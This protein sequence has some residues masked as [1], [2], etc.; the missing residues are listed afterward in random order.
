MAT[1][2]ELMRAMLLQSNGVGARTYGGG[3]A[4]DHARGRDFERFRS[5]PLGKLFL[6]ESMDAQRAAFEQ[7]AR[8]GAFNMQYGEMPN[9]AD[10][11]R[12]VNKALGRNPAAAQ[13]GLIPG[14]DSGPG[15]IPGQVGL[16]GP[17][18][19]A[20]AGGLGLNDGQLSA[21]ISLS[22][23]ADDEARNA[24]V[25]K[26]ENEIR[27]GMDDLYGRVMGRVDNYNKAEAE[28]IESQAKSQ[29]RSH[30]ARNAARGLSNATIDGAFA[31]KVDRDRD[32][33]LQD[34]SEDTDERAIRHDIDLTRDKNDFVEGITDRI[35]DTSQ[36]IA[37]LQSLGAGS[38]GLF[39]SGAAGRPGGDGTPLVGNLQGLAGSRQRGPM[40]TPWGAVQQASYFPGAR[41]PIHANPMINPLNPMAAIGMQRG[42]VN[43]IAPPPMPT[44]GGN[45]RGVIRRPA[46]EEMNPDDQWR[47]LQGM[48]QGLANR[49][50]QRRRTQAKNMRARSRRLLP[51]SSNAFNP[52]VHYV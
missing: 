22:M 26:R 2:E 5:S 38:G 52:D 41:Q 49:A 16:P 29:K 20:G 42:M 10:L 31:Q 47:S 39:G 28:R 15:A 35:P 34:L 27:T 51:A 45:H 12:W 24:A 3:R 37:A 21:L 40:M 8:G 17:I 1:A 7:F 44:A 6:N 46:F 19:Q 25:K 11:Q 23:M 13:Q 50:D 18:G 36:L 48:A 32:F 33:R 9:E 14:R 4:A 30:E 43:Q